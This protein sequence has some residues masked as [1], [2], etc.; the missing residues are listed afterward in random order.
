MNIDS[1]EKGA[2]WGALPSTAKEVDP[3]ATGG[4]S[5]EYLVEMNF[6]AARVR[7]F[8]VVPVDD[9]NPH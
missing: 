4:K 3:V 5:S 7:I 9:E 8:P 6:S 2:G 1:I